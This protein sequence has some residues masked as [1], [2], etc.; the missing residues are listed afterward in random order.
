M[1]KPMVLR[2]WRSCWSRPI[3]TSPTWPAPRWSDADGKR[4]RAAIAT[5]APLSCR[6]TL[7]RRG[8]LARVAAFGDARRLAGAAAQIIEL[9]ATH[10]TLADDGNR[11]DVGRIEREDALDAFAERNLADGERRAHALVGAGDA[12]AL[13]IL[14]AG[15][16]A[17]DHLD[18]DAQR[19]TRAEFGDLVGL[20]ELGDLLGL[21]GLDEVH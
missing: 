10:G 6:P 15:A 9:G 18:A 16:V 17:L 8:G 19:V 4:A 14:H 13:E 12:H 5:R 3:S 21:E 1:P 20:V 2:R 7:F 11:L